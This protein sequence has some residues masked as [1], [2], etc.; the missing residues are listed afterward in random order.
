[1]A[2][3][4]AED[5]NHDEVD[6]E[7]EL[8]QG[9][10]KALEIDSSGLSS[11]LESRSDGVRLKL[12]HLSFRVSDLRRSIQFYVNFLGLRVVVML[13]HDYVQLSTGGSRHALT[14]IEVSSTSQAGQFGSSRATVGH[15]HVAFAVETPQEFYKCA[16][17]VSEA[18]S[19]SR[20]IDHDIRWSLYFRDPDKNSIEITL[21]RRLPNSSIQ[22]HLSEEQALEMSNVTDSDFSTIEEAESNKVSSLSSP[23]FRG[24]T[25]HLSLEAVREEAEKGMHSA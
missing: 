23:S 18:I 12:D 14:L 21:D 4:N 13:P 24:A 19:S 7:F 5:N 10:K 8:G 1:M 3:F 16:K 17:K 25:K 6:S 2:S 22:Q 15:G 9:S 11:L 20:L